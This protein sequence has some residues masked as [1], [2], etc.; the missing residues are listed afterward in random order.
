[1]DAPGART[2]SGKQQQ[3]RQPQTP[4]QRATTATPSRHSSSSSHE[5]V[6]ASHFAAATAASVYSTPLKALASPL[7]RAGAEPPPPSS[8][9]TASLAAAQTAAANHS[10]AAA[11][12]A[13]NA[14]F[15]FGASAFRTSE[16]DAIGAIDRELNLA[17]HEAVDEYLIAMDEAAISAR[18]AGAGAFALGAIED[19]GVGVEQTLQQ[20]QRQHGIAIDMD[21]DEEGHVGADIGEEDQEEDADENVAS[22][23]TLRGGVLAAAP[24]TATPRR[25]PAS[26]ALL[27]SAA[28]GS[29]STVSFG[30]LPSASAARRAD[31]LNAETPTASAAAPASA[32]RSKSAMANTPTSSLSSS[33][34]AT[35]SGPLSFERTSVRSPAAVH[36]GLLTSPSSSS[37]TSA[38]FSSTGDASIAATLRLAQ[39]Q[40]AALDAALARLQQVCGHFILWLS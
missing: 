33:A 7:A 29:R 28:S 37:A 38:P 10:D 21:L 40:H 15:A 8:V 30:A 27:R 6:D 4:Q 24:H 32:L 39:S 12:A 13:S 18:D 22:P 2:P 19:A 14:A 16:R 5:G 31:I 20:Q 26:H 35:L 3:Q 23:S 1:L 34:A 17:M 25:R 11:V 9:S 36:A